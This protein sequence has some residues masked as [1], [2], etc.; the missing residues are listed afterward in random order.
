MRRML[1][2]VVFGSLLGISVYLPKVFVEGYTKKFYE[3]PN[4]Y[5]N[6]A[7]SCQEPVSM[8]DAYKNELLADQFKRD[9]VMLCF[10]R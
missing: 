4:P 7:N 5:L 3:E 8:L 10:C 2:L 1:S 9:D 6:R